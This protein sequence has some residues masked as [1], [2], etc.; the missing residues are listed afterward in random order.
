[1]RFL[2]S[3]C[4][5]VAISRTIF[6]LALRWNNK[7]IEVTQ[8]YHSVRQRAEYINECCFNKGLLFKVVLKINDCLEMGVQA[9]SNSEV[10]CDS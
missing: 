9:L 2:T 6:E 8:F 3:F 10:S 7:L 4:F 1:M 5:E